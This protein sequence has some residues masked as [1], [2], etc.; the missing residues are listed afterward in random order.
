MFSSEVPAEA[1]GGKVVVLYGATFAVVLP[2]QDDSQDKRR[3]VVCGEMFWDGDV[4]W[5]VTDGALI[6]ARDCRRD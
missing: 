2:H 3:C 5:R 1:K 4:A 6:C